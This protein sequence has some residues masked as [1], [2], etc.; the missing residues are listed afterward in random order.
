M[1]CEDQL[2]ME[3]LLSDS[4]A[5]NQ[6]FEFPTKSLINF[7]MPADQNYFNFVAVD[8][9]GQP[10]ELK[11]SVRNEGTHK[12]PW[13][14]GQWRRYVLDKGLKKGD[15]VK[16]IM[17]VRENGVRSYPSFGSLEMDHVEVMS[18][19]LS[20]SDA[21]NDRLEFP[22]R[23]LG[24]FPISADNKQVHFDALDMLG[25]SWSLKISIRKKGYP[26][27]WISGEWGL[28]ARQ[29]RL[30]Q[31]DRVR[32]TMA[33]QENGVRNIYHIEAERHLAMG[34]WIPIEEWHKLEME[35]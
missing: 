5:T 29:K 31:G 34:M 24:G 10:R 14:S 18:K 7:P 9:V 30:R 21:T 11:I 13:M 19:L 27:P 33:V 17:Q 35:N 28:Y 2:V 25:Q 4:D 22:S 23:S 6:R 26:K 15:R 32:L 20:E 16:L 8:M 3:K 12:K 1:E